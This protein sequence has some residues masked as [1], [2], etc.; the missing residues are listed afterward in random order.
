[1]NEEDIMLT[2]EQIEINAKRCADA[3]KA[4]NDESIALIRKAVFAMSGVK[5]GARHE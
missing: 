2:K 1:V 5:E 4:L 3:I